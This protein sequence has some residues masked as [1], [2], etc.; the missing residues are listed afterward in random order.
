MHNPK[1]AVLILLAIGLALVGIAHAQGSQAGGG[2]YVPG[3]V[4]TYNMTW[5]INTECPLCAHP[6]AQTVNSY[7]WAAGKQF[8]LVIRDL[9][10]ATSLT[11]R[12]INSTANST[13]FVTFHVKANA[14]ELNIYTKWD[15]ALL[16]N[17]H[18]YYFLLYEVPKFNGTFADL[19]G[20]L[21]GHYYTILGNGTILNNNYNYSGFVY[22]NN[23]NVIYYNYTRV[24]G[25][26]NNFNNASGNIYV[27][28]NATYVNNKS[29][30]YYNKINYTYVIYNSTSGNYYRFLYNGTGRYYIYNP[31]D[32]RWH[33]YNA[34]LGGIIPYVLV[35]G[36]GAI[37]QVNGRA[38]FVNFTSAVLHQFYLGVGT[39]GQ[40]YNLALVENL[41]VSGTPAYTWTYKPLSSLKIPEGMVFGPITYLGTYVPSL[42]SAGQTVG[43]QLSPSNVSYTFQVVLNI[44]NPQTGTYVKQALITSTNKIYTTY[45]PAPI[46][47]RTYVIETL[48]WTGVSYNYTRD[49]PQPT[50]VNATCQQLVIWPLPLSTLTVGTLLDIKGNQILSPEYFVFKVQEN[51]GG[52]PLTIDQGTGGWTT[53][54]PPSWFGTL[55]FPSWISTWLDNHWPQYPTLAWIA[56][57]LT[58]SDNTASLSSLS[59]SPRLIVE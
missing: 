15:V 58:L 12:I 23:S 2:L 48:N 51:I 53:L 50:S 6:W 35:N 59:L 52:Y 38:N 3:A 22:Y 34:T 57:I 49:S 45:V 24:S 33:L 26:F 5:Q 47:N 10:K 31:T 4:V 13:G 32:N 36:W 7:S 20:N 44:S 25:T 29:Y 56:G 11:N 14:S 55:P 8:T 1:T 16:V 40:P 42:G 21:T 19:M 17:W 18:G 37:T 27:Y 39:A 28:L 41:S 9:N 30:S 46:S 54:G 43:S